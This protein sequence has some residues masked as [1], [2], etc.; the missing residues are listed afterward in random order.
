MIC[1][2]LLINTSPRLECR[3][4]STVEKPE[5]GTADVNQYCATDQ[6][7]SCPNYQMK[8]SGFK[9]DIHREVFRALG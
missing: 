5:V 3:C 2:N 6:Y 4:A 9:R 1:P 7:A 8:I